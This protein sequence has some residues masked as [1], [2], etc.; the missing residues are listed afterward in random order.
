MRG[1]G[2]GIRLAHAPEEIR[3]GA[4]V[5]SMEPSLALVECFLADS[6]SCLLAGNCRLTGV[7]D[8]ALKAFLTHLDQFTLADLLPGLPHLHAPAPPEPSIVAC[9]HK[10][11]KRKARAKSWLSR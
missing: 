1:K 11:K 3:I 6:N 7:L 9:I 2:G 5:R 4:V 10:A 8:G